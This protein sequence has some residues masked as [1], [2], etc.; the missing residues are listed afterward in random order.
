MRIVDRYL[1]KIKTEKRRLWR[2]ITILTA[3]SFLVVLAVA[4]NLRLTGVTIANGA[5]CQKEEHQH[6]EACYEL[7]DVC[8]LEEHIHELACYS[9]YSA[10]VETA[11]QWIGTIPEL[12]GIQSE[13]LIQ[14]AISQLGNGESELN[15]EL[16]EDGETKKGITRYGQWYGNPYGDWATMFTSFCL[17]YAEIA[18]VPLNAGAETMRL[19]WVERDIYRLKENYD[20]LP[21]DV[22]FLDKNGDGTAS[23]TA[24]IVARDETTLTVIEG[25]IENTVAEVTYK[26]DEEVIIGYGLTTPKEQL[27]MFSAAP[28][29]AMQT[30]GNTVKYSSSIFNGSTD[31]IL[32]VKGSGG[33]Y[34]AIDGNANAVEIQ[35]DSSGAI[36]SDIDNPSM[37][38]WSFEHCG[39]D[40]GKTTYYIR[41]HQ[42]G[43]Y[44]HPYR[45]ND[46]SH[47][48][49]LSGR[50]ESALHP[51]GDGVKIRGARQKVYAVLSGSRFTDSTTENGGSVL[52]FGKIPESCTVWL[53]GTLGGLMGFD[54]SPN[55]KNTVS[56]GGTITLPT[57]WQ[58]PA[59]YQYVLRG[60]YDVTNSRYYS[61]GETVLVMDDM[62]LYADWIPASYDVGKYNSYVADTVSTNKFVTTHMF[63]YNSL[64]NVM[65][66]RPTV[67]VNGSGHSETWNMV[68]GTGQVPYKDAKTIDFIFADWDNN[69]KLSRP[70]GIN[71]KNNYNANSDTMG[72]YN[73]TLGNILFSTE[74]AWNPDTKEGIIGKSYLGTGDHLFQ[75]V[76]DPNDEHYG[77][78]YYDSTLN[79][80]AY[81]QSNGRFYVYDYLER[82][83]D[84]AAANDNWKYSDFLPL[85]SPYTNTN[86]KS[87]K[88]YSYGGVN[89]E[90][91]AVSHYQYDGK[92]NTDGNSTANIG[93]NYAFGMSI[94]IEFYLPNDPGTADA[95][96]DLYGKD[97][98]FKFSGD[99]D[100]WIFVDGKMVLDIGDIHGV[101]HGEINFSTGIITYD[102]GSKGK[103]NGV[104]AG[105]HTLTI[106]YLERGSSQSNCAI[107]FNLAPRFQLD[108]TKEDVLSQKLLDGAEFAVYTDEACTKPAK[109]WE[110]EQAHDENKASTNIF[111]F[112]DGKSSLWGF[113][114][115]NKYYLKETKPPNEV[116][117]DSNNDDNYLLPKGI[118]CIEFDKSG[119]ASSKV[120]VIKE[121]GVISNGFTVHGFKIDEEKHQASIIVTNAPDWVIETTTVQVIKIWNDEKNHSGDYVTA[122]LTVTDPDGTVRRIREIVLG[123][124][125]DWNHTWT[126]LPKYAEDGVTEIKYGT[127]ETFTD[128]YYSEVERVEENVSLEVTW[129]D[130]YTFENQKTYLLKEGNSYLSTVSEN[131]DTLRWVDEETAKNSSLAKWTAVTNGK[132]VRLTNEAGQTLSYVYH[133]YHYFNVSSDTNSNQTF[134]IRQTTNGVQLYQNVNQV[135]YYIGPLGSNGWMTIQELG[136]GGMLTFTPVVKTTNMV[137]EELADIAYTITNTPLDKATSFKVTKKWEYPAGEETF[138]EESQVTVKLFANGVDTGRTV[139]L[140]LKNGW[141][142]T[143]KGLPYVDSEGNV[144]SYTVQ[145]SWQTQDWVASYGK[146]IVVDGTIPTYETVV[147][148]VYQWLSG[149]ELPATGGLGYHINVLIGLVLVLMPFVYG[150]KLRRRYE[151]RL[152]E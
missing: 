59:K 133:Y 111:K 109:L 114:A 54:G 148:N 25:D 2:S 64:F 71:D 151:R 94:D 87:L 127:V 41:N 22:L 11:E 149:A 103:L 101:R 136:W 89:G 123:Q 16:A 90:Y 23:T 58:S 142:D 135:D 21:G 66:E 32:Y 107:Y 139:T 143:F 34:Y 77:Y 1:E 5:T 144:I 63:D 85:N 122:Y 53:D 38:Y 134:K 56:S 28:A 27:L 78:Y 17:H 125:N 7:V 72:I 31:F 29:A 131:S 45:N 124:E 91:S 67:T 37:L 42:T 40:E 33:R 104:T 73:E 79:A 105:E 10:D 98:N 65:A 75:I 12:S 35:I 132:E 84:S 82:T 26:I 62:V 81:N 24:I 55:Q 13:D 120:S 152:K 106:Y 97:M 119:L 93:T 110:S 48:A 128:G 108:I 145:E 130:A 68:T 50:W 44:L 76:T 14:V 74:N 47:D 121:N 150:F 118:I 49:I 46:S 69:G 60:W 147:T 15:F 4:W 141:T 80:S 112:V 3:L 39:T 138:Y 6:T 83:S 126:S 20:P 18:D 88:N 36:Q 113:G 19:E 96:K 70:S 129:A 92:Y 30:I 137:V 99:D 116:V 9:D 100:V 140:N 115:G 117:G 95:N 61:P 51:N 8:E 57:E 146:I 43:M 86:G 52:L 102:G